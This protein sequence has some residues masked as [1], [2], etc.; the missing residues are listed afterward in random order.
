M[1]EPTVRSRRKAGRR[2]QLLAAAAE[3]FAVRGYLGVR[4]EDLGSAVGVSGP[5]VYRHFA[6][7]ESVLVE[8]LVGI[9]ERLLAGGRAAVA[10]VDSAADQLA[11]LIEFHTE[12]AVADSE[13]IRIQDRDLAQLPPDS[14]HEVRKLQRE[15]VELW[16]DV[17]CRVDSALDVAEARVKVHAAIGLMNSTPHIADDSRRRLTVLLASMT[18][19]ALGATC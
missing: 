19:K 1:S 5:A 17:L 8:L 6:N 14:E 12:F 18:S 9:S 2:A 3:L 15:Y 13:L 11:A 4:L 10:G 7:K 16:V